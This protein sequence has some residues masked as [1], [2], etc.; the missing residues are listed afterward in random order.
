MLGL[1]GRAPDDEH[2]AGARA[3]SSAGA[4]ATSR[5]P[6]VG[7]HG[8]TLPPIS[9]LTSQS[10]S[11]INVSAPAPT[12]LTSLGWPEL[13][14]HDQQQ[15]QDQ[16]ALSPASARA[17]TPTT[18]DGSPRVAYYS[19]QP[20]RDHHLGPPAH[21]AHSG[22]SVGSSSSQPP[23]ASGFQQHLQTQPYQRMQSPVTATSSVLPSAP[24]TTTNAARSQSPSQARAK[25]KPSPVC[26]SCGT[27]STPLWRR[28]PKGEHICNACGLAAKAR[29]NA[30]NADATAHQSNAAQRQGDGSARTE[31]ASRA[32]SDLPMPSPHKD[33]SAGTADAP[34][35]R[36]A[37]ATDNR[38]KSIA[39][40]AE[41]ASA[42]EHPPPTQRTTE[43]TCPGDGE[44]N[45]QGGRPCCQGCPALNNRILHSTSKSSQAADAI[46]AEND[47][48]NGASS[49]E[50]GIMECVNCGTRTTPLWRRDGEGRV[51]CN[52]CGLYYKLHGVHRPGQMKKPTIKRRKRTTVASNIVSGIASDDAAAAAS[53]AAGKTAPAA[54]LQQ[55]SG[56]E[57]GASLNPQPKRR[58]TTKKAAATATPQQ[59]GATGSTSVDALQAVRKSPQGMTLPELAAVASQLAPAAARPTPQG[60]T[61]ASAST[62]APVAAPHSH[63]HSHS[64]AHSHPLHHHHHHHVAPHVARHSSGALAHLH[65]VNLDTPLDHL[66]LRD[67]VTFHDGLQA[68][69]SSMRELMTRTE[70]YLAHGDRLAGVVQQAI[71]SASTRTTTSATPTVDRS[72]PSTTAP[73]PAPAPA[74][75]SAAETISDPA[76]T[77]APPKRQTEQDLE[78]LLAGMPNMPAVPLPARKKVVTSTDPAQ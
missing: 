43:G 51:A 31:V 65:H 27:T 45:G 44:C 14:G 69:L 66:T 50:V 68:E 20:Q 77:P 56:E 22:S 26:S 34:L 49:G 24:K 3:S 36:P 61:A 13:G 4:R 64:H 53:S 19:H 59:Q 46:K 11:S 78:E 60:S 10:A 62:T 17:H 15:Q 57:S 30:R 72:V 25:D 48:D 7:H 74:S 1:A 76:P 41:A 29:Q 73:A 33:T 55:L 16:R 54:D 37:Q 18:A 42:T 23:L 12:K 58:K 9:A 47:E 6:L 5:S 71:T 28:S 67:L 75:A 35:V 32:A 8:I 70:Q 39:A 52:A 63:S 2:V 21:L 40:L 38:T